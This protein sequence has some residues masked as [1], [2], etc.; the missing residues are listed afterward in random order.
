MRR[1]QDDPQPQEIN[2]MMR[3]EEL[4]RLIQQPLPDCTVQLDRINIPG[5]SVNVNDLS[6]VDKREINFTQELEEFILSIL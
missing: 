4:D 1:K 5:P 2:K 3:R 6:S